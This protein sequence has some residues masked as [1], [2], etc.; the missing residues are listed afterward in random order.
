[1]KKIIMILFLGLLSS[2]DPGYNIYIANRS[3]SNILIETDPAISSR[4]FFSNSNPDNDSVLSKKVY[5]SNTN[6]LYKLTKNQE[7]RLFSNVGFP[8]QNYF[9]YKSV[10][11]IRDSD[12]L[13]IDKSNMMQKIIKKKRGLYY[14]NIE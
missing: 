3:K 11:I 6:N 9:P 1:M 13:K 2:C 12:T 7:I 5:S 14:I 10:K 8:S 4:T